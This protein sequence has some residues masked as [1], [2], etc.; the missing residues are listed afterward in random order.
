VVPPLSLADR[1]EIQELIA[2][3]CWALDTR[4]GDAY[5]ATF[6]PDGV[7]QGVTTFARGHDQLRA[8]PLALHPDRIETQHWVTNLVLEGDGQRVTARSYAIA[9]RADSYYLAHYLDELVK[10]DGRWQFARRQF[11]RWP[12]GLA[13][14]GRPPLP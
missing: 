7:F 6:I 1:L 3:Y 9:Y 10:V 4:D 13:D 14:P 8:L 11:W 2:R 12:D 5:A